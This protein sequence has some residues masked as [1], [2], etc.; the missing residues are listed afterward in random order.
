MGLFGVNLTAMDRDMGWWF[1][2]GWLA[3]IIL[4]ASGLYH[5]LVGMLN[6]YVDRISRKGASRYR[7]VIKGPPLSDMKLLDDNY[8]RIMRA[9]SLH[10][11]K[12]YILIVKLASHASIAVIGFVAWG[13]AR[14]ALDL[15]D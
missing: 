4:P 6:T 12:V 10:R 1:L 8:S 5:L 7:P 14:I 15:P 9:T 3:A 11:A 2:V 13:I